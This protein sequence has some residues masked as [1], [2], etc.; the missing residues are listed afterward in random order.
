LF[1]EGALPR[2][3]FDQATVGLTQA[4]AQY[5]L[6]KKHLDA[7]NAVVKQQ[8]LKSLKGQLSSAHGKYLGAKAQLSYS[9]IRSPIDGYVTERPL[10]P[11]DVPAPGSPI[12]IVMDM[13]RVTARAHIPQTDAALL[14]LGDNAMITQPG[15]DPVDG[16]VSLIGPALDPNSTTVE[17][18]VEAKNPQQKLKPGS[19]V[20]VSMVA[21][22]VANALVVPASA[23]L[24]GADGSTTAPSHHLRP[25]GSYRP[26]HGHFRSAED[27]RRP[28]SAKRYSHR[29]RRNV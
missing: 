6:A 16:K 27:R 4:R 23:L 18:W 11:G 9:E 29:I 13:S 5:E 19:S 8:E 20:R 3:D 15:M 2:K 7:L 26:R 10:Y 24:T 1:K 28:A 21:K 25:S 14:K 12:M 17:V 22:S